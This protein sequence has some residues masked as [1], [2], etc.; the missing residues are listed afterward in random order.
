MNKLLIAVAVLGAFSGFAAAQSNVTIYGLVDAGI[1]SERGGAKGNATKLS[2]GVG[3]ATRLGFRGTEDLGGGL[4]ANFVLESGP[5]IDTG[6]LD[7][8]GTIFNRQA[9]VGLKGGFGALTLGRQYTPYFVTISTVADPFT[10]GYA[11]SAKN[12]LPTVGTNTRTSNTIQYTSPKL[13]GFSGELAYSVGEQASSNSAGRQ[14]GAAL[15][16]TNGPLNARLAYNNKNT[17]VTAAAAT[18][19]VPVASNGIARNTLLAANYNFGV[20]K[21]FL[22][23]GIDKGKNSAVLPTTKT[24]PNP[25]GVVAPQNKP[26][27]SIDSRDLLVGV[28]LPMGASTILASYIRKDDRTSLNQ[29]ASQWALG[30]TYALSKRTSLYSSYAKI[31][32]EN[33]AAYTVGN[34][35]EV[36][37]GD[38]AFNLGVRHSF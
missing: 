13:S 3:S 31:K 9:Y 24:N 22:A 28:A 29:D 21:G 27:A 10:A 20:V 14:F 19:A 37:T 38:Q 34:N 17:D 33:G 12:L 15:A 1:V 2:S 23:F 6:E 30:Y 26:V 8:A 36:G 4:S 5:R 7:V 35:T 11:G 18:A 16:Y 32:N 25:F